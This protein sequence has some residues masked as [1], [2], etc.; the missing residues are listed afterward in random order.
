M[1]I[2]FTT[3][4]F[5]H[6]QKSLSEALNRQTSEEY[7]FL[8]AGHMDEERIRLGWVN[9]QFPPYVK[10]VEEEKGI[11]EK[12]DV[13]IAGSF[14][15]KYIHKYIRMKKLMFRYSERP[16]K[17]GIELNKYI[18]RFIKWHIRNPFGFPI[19]LL[20]ASA[21]TSLD[22]S[23]FGLFRNRCYKWG[24]FPE[25][26]YYDSFAELFSKKDP[27]S[28]LWCG[29]F[30]EW[31]H[32]ESALKAAERL[33]EERIPFKMKLIGT[34]ELEEQIRQWITDRNLQ[35]AVELMGAVSSEKVRDYME[36]A[37]IFL[38]TSDRRE[39]WGAVL[40][41]A[42]NSGCAVVAS[43]AIGSVPYLL[44]NKE[45]GFVY[46]SGDV[47]E[48]YLKVR[49]LLQHTEEQ[50]NAGIRAYHTIADVWN[51]EVAAKRFIELAQ[52]ILNG[53]KSPKLFEDG[54]CSCAEIIR[55]DWYT[56]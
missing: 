16:L 55:E 29:R 32:P 52:E 53:N 48:L 17:N 20:C 24:Y 31:K 1:K 42:M 36:E 27:L 15:E 11:L 4:F 2:V 12:A 47:D 33:K 56:K 37:G 13:I 43:D 40:N 35:D 3:N 49:Y 46:H 19:Y 41:E 39:G 38:F 26:R 44:K 54:P 30:L 23:R 21:F 22:Y 34:G 9:Q 51:A 8:T 28:I 25:T 45:N 14:P 50:K 6:H 5:N 18:G 7:A 10:Q